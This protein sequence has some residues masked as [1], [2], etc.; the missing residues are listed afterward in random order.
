MNYLLAL[1]SGLVLLAVLISGCTISSPQAPASP[2]ATLASQQPSATPAPAD[3][4]PGPAIT[5]TSWKLGWFDDTNGVW[6]KVAEGST[7]TAMF[8]TDEKVTGSSGC[9]EYSTDYHL[10]TDP[11]I[12]IRRPEVPSKI[13]QAPFGV[14]KQEAHYDTDLGWAVDYAITNN[15]LVMFDKTGKK[16]LQFDPA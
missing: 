14:M 3:G 5:G 4:T 7:I 16:I 11:K 8:G 1:C 2:A 6:S 15:Q 9:S 10:G 12:W 13:C